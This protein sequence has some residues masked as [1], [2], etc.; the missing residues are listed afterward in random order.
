MMTKDR[1]STKKDFETPI[2]YGAKSPW[3]KAKVG[4]SI[5]KHI[6]NDSEH[7]FGL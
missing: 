7:E 5:P 4:L 2:I 6:V 1:R 3:G